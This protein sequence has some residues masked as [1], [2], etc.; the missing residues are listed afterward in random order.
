MC[1]VLPVDQMHEVF[2]LG[3]RERKCTGMTGE[4]R[5]YL[6]YNLQAFQ[7]RLCFRPLSMDASQGQRAAG[8]GQ[9]DSLIE[10]G[11]TEWDR[12]EATRKSGKQ[13]R[14]SRD[15]KRVT[16]ST[17]FTILVLVP[18]VT[19]LGLSPR[20]TN[21]DPFDLSIPTVYHLIAMGV[22][23]VSPFLH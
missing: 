12:G 6:R 22:A 9:S 1:F 17:R 23:T 16:P 19:S 10:L 11:M 4:A 7:T 20:R 18:R 8:R 21:R 13:I 5:I 14:K 15:R 2:S 3:Y